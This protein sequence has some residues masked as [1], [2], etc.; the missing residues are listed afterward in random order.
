MFL[1]NRVCVCVTDSGIQDAL[2][3]DH[4]ARI[5]ATPRYALSVT[6][7]SN[8]GWDRAHRAAM[9]ID[10]HKAEMGVYHMVRRDPK[11]QERY[12]VWISP[13]T[14]EQGV[15]ELSIA[16]RI[17]CLAYAK[18]FVTA[19][20]SKDVVDSSG[21]IKHAIKRKLEGELRFYRRHR[22]EPLDK[23]FGA[24]KETMSGKA[25]GMQDDLCTSLHQGI[26]MIKHQ[27]GDDT[28][29]DWVRE[30]GSHVE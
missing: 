4:F 3:M 16:L 19:P 12:G 25:P 26:F 10:T 22:K 28:F 24:T 20:H 1:T 30:H 2:I 23:H 21:H 5:R 14:K 6:F 18:E 29:R 11:Q 8:Y 9:M 17:G 15:E 13:S 7:E 27:R